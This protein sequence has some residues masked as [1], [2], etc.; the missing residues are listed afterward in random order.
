M[1]SILLT[2][3]S[4]G[5]QCTLSIHLQSTGDI[6]ITPKAEG[7]S[8]ILALNLWTMIPLGS[9]DLFTGVAWCYQKTQIFTL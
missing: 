6:H 1:A 8:R 9:N 5:F 4:L 2:D 3:P 7:K